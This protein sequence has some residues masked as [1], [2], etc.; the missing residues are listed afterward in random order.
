MV[1]SV[2]P[3]SCFTLTGSGKK[4]AWLHPHTHSWCGW[5]WA[6][7]PP[8]G[9]PTNSHSGAHIHFTDLVCAVQPCFLCLCLCLGLDSSLPDTNS[10]LQLGTNVQ[11]KK[12]SHTKGSSCQLSRPHTLVAH[13]CHSLSDWKEP[14]VSGSVARLFLPETNQVLWSNEQP[15]VLNKRHNLVNSFKTFDKF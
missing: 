6:L 2:S 11:N 8:A 9:T 15:R 10:H 1:S 5:R 12:P 3:Q 7:V 13:R 14:F 4:T